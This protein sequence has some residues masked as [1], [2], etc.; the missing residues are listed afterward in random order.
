MFIIIG[1][2]GA[3]QRVYAAFKFFLYTLFGSV[4]ML[5]AM[6]IVILDPSVLQ[7]QIPMDITQIT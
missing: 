3:E 7:S 6:L 1:V 5:I 4:F 2:W